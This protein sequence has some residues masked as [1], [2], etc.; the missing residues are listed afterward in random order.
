L[1]R[2]AQ[3]VALALSPSAPRACAA[4]LDPDRID[5]L[6]MGDGAADRAY[7]A[8][9]MTPRTVPL[10]LLLAL[11]PVASPR[12]AEPARPAAPAAAP[13]PEIPYE[14]FRLNN[15]LTVIVHEDRT[16]PIVGVHVQYDVGAKDEKPGRTGFA[17]LFEHLMFQGSENLPKGT[18]DRIIEAAGG[19]TNGSTS[20]DTTQYW[21]QAPS[22]ALEQ[23]LWIEADRMG[24]LLPTLTQ[25]K[26]D[27]QRDVV[28]NERRQSY[29][30]RP[31]G[32][33]FERILANLWNAE[34]PYH[35]MPIGS[36]EDLQAASLDDVREFFK[37]YYGPEN[38]VLAIAGDVD[39][40]R[41]RALVEKWF[42]G[43]PGKPPPIHQ[44]PEPVPI[45]TEKRITMEDRV[46]LP[47]LYVAW[48]SPKVFAPG[49][50]A[51]DLAAQILTDGKSARLVKR[52]VMDERIAQDVSAGQMSQTLGSMFIVTATPKPGVSLER[53]ERELDEELARLAQTPPSAEELERAKNKVEAGAIFGLEPVGGFGG[54]A[55]TLAGYYLRTGD[56]GYLDEDLA[57]YREATADDVSQAVRSFLRKDAR[58]VLSVT[59]RAAAPSAAPAPAAAKGETR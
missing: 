11:A 51:L 26:L 52:L 55:A 42:G 53:L 22:N 2:D 31:Y 39:T 59:P 56:P 25:E 14:M 13:A 48:Q 32:L 20:Q 47:R 18:A 43:I 16:N 12:G 27:N 54:R 44:K 5:S 30:M 40:A 37:R 8:D 46:Q 24:F 57:R 34:F 28:R 10:A 35:W 58:V 33:A 1:E 36:H 41:V 38:A 4:A 45:R 50:A 6:G 17:H 19:D 23:M 7:K 49:D 21:E 15:G 9:S 3:W 29:E